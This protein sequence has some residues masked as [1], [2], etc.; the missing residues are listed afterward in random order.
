MNRS[1]LTALVLIALPLSAAQ[2][3]RYNRG[4][5]SVHQPVVQRHDYVLDVSGDG[6]DPVAAT[7]V[8]QWFDAIG[9]DYGDRISIDG[10]AGNSGS[11]RAIAAIVGDYGLFVSN[12][13][14]V[15]EGVIAPGNVRIIVSRSTASVPGCPDYSQ[16]SQP[17]FTGAATSN[18]GCGI[19]STLAAMVANPED[20]VRGQ[21]ARG[22]NAETAAKAIRIW[23]N[24][25][26]T[27]KNGL[28]LES[29]KG[30]N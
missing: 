12:G 11:S 27:A 28:K 3:G 19:N 4:V 2:A 1:V 21:E 10:S 22:G 14:P 8:R 16:A 23:R 25:D 6:L 18:Y 9:L 24:A 29:T 17:N 26:P 20:L 30:G 13:A 5:E 7:R 15:T